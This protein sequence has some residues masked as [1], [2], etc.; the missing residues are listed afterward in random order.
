MSTDEIKTLTDNSNT[1]IDQNYR[2]VTGTDIGTDKRALD[3]I[4]QR[5]SVSSSSAAQA[6]RIDT[7]GST[8]YYGFADV[9]SLDASAVWRIFRE[10]KSGSVTSFTYA[11]G[12][13]NFDNIWDNRVSLSYS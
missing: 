9:G 8:T 10:T 6:V 3:V 7:S 13:S 11:D 2:S 5:T 1:S 12:D 4:I